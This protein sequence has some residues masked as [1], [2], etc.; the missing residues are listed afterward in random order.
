MPAASW[1]DDANTALVTDLYQLTM[2]QAYWREGMRGEATFDLFVRRLPPHRSYL[3]ACGL[4]GALR[5]LETVRFP[6]DAL[7]YL[8]TLGLFRDD[9]LAA[10]A[11]FRFTGAVRAVPEGTVV[12]PNEPILEVT[13]PIAE[14]QLV[15]TFLLNQ[16]TLQTVVASKA[17]RV[18]RA[19]QGRAVSDFGMRRAHGADA[20]LKG[21]RAMWIAGVSSTSNVE[22]GRVYGI[23]VAGTMAHSY[24]EAHESEADAFRAFAALYPETVLLVDT[25]DTLAGVRQV[26]A[27]AREL[28]EAFRVRA[29]RLDSGD[30][31]VLAKEARALLDEAGLTGVRLVA[32]SSLDEYRIAALLEAGA[33]I[34]AFGVGTRMATSQDAPALDA[35]YKLAAYDG[36]PRMKLAEGKD[37]LPGRKQ[38]WRR[39]GPDGRFAGDVIGAAEEA[40]D[41]TPL[42]VEVMRDGRRLGA[43]PLDAIRARAQAQLDALP[44][45]LHALDPPEAA[46]P[47]VVS[48][49]LAA[50]RERVRAALRTRHGLAG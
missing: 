20:A 50:E 36:T 19:A 49:R 14:A 1:T 6:A 9:F 26:V 10:L 28:G 29:L 16:I 2:L 21:A 41:G 27:L 15:E 5:Y 23:P 3:L 32:S 45:A 47:V 39:T 44:E 38:V 7:A 48:E 24:I 42:L 8:A 43:E 18:V 12:F 37:T 25:Y 17:A 40:C 30:L 35:V 34:D 4:D 13:A 33:P 46:Y 31:A 11:D 22:A